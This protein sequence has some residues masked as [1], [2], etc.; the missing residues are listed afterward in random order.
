[1]SGLLSAFLK[2]VSPEHIFTLVDVG[3]MGGIEAEW[4]RI[5]DDIRV[6]GFEPD[7]REF[8]KL[9]S[10][11]TRLYL[12]LAVSQE[13]KDLKFYVSREPGKSS[14]YEPNLDELR[15]FPSAQRFETVDKVLIPASRVSTLDT[16]L[17]KHQIRDVDFLK[18]DTQGNE[19]S[20]L[21]GSRD[22]LRE[23]VLGLK[24]EVEFLEM[25][26]DQPLFADVDT[27]VRA[28]GFQLMDLRRAY[29]KRIDH[30]NFVGKGQLVFG[31]AL[32][33]K[34]AEA[35]VASLKNTD[36]QY[37]RDKTI[38]FVA[39]CLVYGLR[40]HAVFL[41][42]QARGHGYIAEHLHA[43]LARMIQINDRRLRNVCFASYLCL[44]SCL[45]LIR[46]RLS[47]HP[48]DWADSDRF[49]GNPHS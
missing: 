20:I 43:E 9:S 1:M 31:D 42:N 12:N 44:R 27:F 37:A 7:E 46:K 36:A 48:L 6:V 4:K 45:R 35:F 2:K 10:S 25:Y 24:V 49:L 13:S 38:K 26:R 3:A 11:P 41:L 32:Y 33:F 29:W 47:P 5:K 23:C 15:G 34:T 39:V 19:L 40:D 30:T 14:V 28:H 17:R 16:T 18:L 21:I 8:S 22:H